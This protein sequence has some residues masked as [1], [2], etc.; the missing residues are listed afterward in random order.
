MF[1]DKSASV[2]QLDEHNDKVRGSNSTH[3]L[4]V[5]LYRAVLLLQKIIRQI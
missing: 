1:T 3:A 2:G 4:R 5:K